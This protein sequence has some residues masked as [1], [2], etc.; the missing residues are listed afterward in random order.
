MVP[1]VQSVASQQ[2]P[3]PYFFPGVTVNAF[4]WEA[5]LGPIQRLC[6]TYYNLGDP[7]ER[8]FVYK[9]LAAWPYATLLLIEYPV[10]MSADP[11][12]LG[13]GGMS[14]ADRG[15]MS[16]H[17]VFVA[18]PLLRYGATAATLLSSAAIEWALPFIVVENPTSAV[19]GREMLGLEKLQGHITFGAGQL[20][21]SFRGEVNLPGWPSLDPNVMQQTM[22]FLTV[23]TGPPTPT[24]FGAPDVASLWTLLQSP[25]ASR[26]IGALGTAA[27]L[28][29]QVS[30]GLIPTAMQVVSLKQIRDAGNPERALFQSLVT[31]RSK[32]A[33]ITD[34]H[35]YKEQDVDITFHADGSFREIVSVFLDTGKSTSFKPIAAY[36]FGADIH[37]DEMR[38][39]YNFPIDRGPGQP[40]SPASGDLLAPWLR[41]LWGFLG[42]RVKP[43]PARAVAQ[44]SM[45]TRGGRA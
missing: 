30:D 11:R 27:D 6:D 36:R 17:E 25:T 15:Y 20:P 37:F 24:F 21:G 31:C 32:Y 12:Q 35:F 3:P 33:N 9:P 39:V 23:T 26:A 7:R 14:Y 4:V 22:P 10:M 16:Q 2:A 1:Y 5:P 18:I 8:G 40:P 29:D 28:V 43:A 34:F 13:L 38:T 42:P 41:P 44:Q 45:S 19:C